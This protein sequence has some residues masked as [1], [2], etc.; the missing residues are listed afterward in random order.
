M[1]RPFILKFSLALSL[2]GIASSI[3]NAEEPLPVLPATEPDKAVQTIQLQDGFRAELIAAEPLL[4]DPVDMVYDENGLAYVVEMRDY[5]YT[6]ANDD[7]P[8]ADQKSAP[9]GRIRILEDTDGDGKFDRSDIF[10]EN[11]SWPAGI[12][13]WKGGVYV[14]ATPDLL[15]L[16][17]TDGDRK[18]DVRRAV[19]SGFRKYNVQAIMN[20]PEWGLD[21]KLYV[22]GSSNG[23]QIVS[24]DKSTPQ[25]LGSNDFCFDPTQEQLEILS[26][27]GRFGNTVDDWGNRFLTN[28]RNPIQHVLFPSRYQKR[29]R[30]LPLTSLIHNVAPSGDAVPVYRVSPPESWRV[31]HAERAARESSPALVDTAAA[32][33]YVTSSSGVTIYRGAAYP[34]EFYGNAFVGEVAGNLV[35]RYILDPAGVTFEG[36]RPYDKKDFMASTD[37]WFRAVNFV[38][39]PDGTLH[40]LDMYRQTVEHPWSMPDDLKKRLDLTA[41]R[42]RGRIYRL[43]PPQYATGFI[44][45][46]QP[47]LGSAT[48]PELVAELENPNGWWRDTAHR[49]LYERQDVAAVPLLKDLLRQSPSTLARLHALWSLEGLNALAADDVAQ[50]LKDTEPRLQAHAVRLSERFLKNAPALLSA[51]QSLADS[52]SMPLRFQVALS[53]GEAPKDEVR[54]ALV[55]ILLR[56][57]ADPWMCSAVLSSLGKEELGL[58]VDL[59]RNGDFISTPAGQAIAVQ[60]APTVGASFPASSMEEVLTVLSQ[61]PRSQRPFQRKLLV[62][63]GKG[64]KRQRITLDSLTTMNMPTEGQILLRQVLDEAIAQ[65]METGR[66]VEERLEQMPVLEFVHLETAIAT[67]EPLIS[68]QTPAPVQ[69]QAIR[70]LGTFSDPRIPE[71]LLGRYRSLT[72]GQQLVV[73][74]LIGRSN[75]VPI[76]FTAI[77]SGMI[78]PARVP[79]VRQEIYMLSPDSVIS[80]RATKIF[81][82]QQQQDLVELLKRYQETMPAT[83]D[84]TRGLEVYQKNCSNCHKLGNHGYEVGPHLA[85]VK[86]RSRDELLVSILDPNKEIAPNFFAYLVMTRDGLLRTGVISVETNTTITLRGADRNE[87]TI[88][89]EDIDEFQNSGKSLMPVGLNKNLTPQQMADLIALLKSQ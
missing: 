17:D 66:P 67:L 60:I 14:A 69:Q 74:Q 50:G 23:G 33:G 87:S 36:R 58:L 55:K 43:I 89:R 27:S 62:N 76:L 1:N 77:E 25:P 15:Y 31:I 30:N 71:I 35:I 73:D 5:P 32:T 84:V 47:R 75:W 57:G 49:L 80:S 13:C 46:P 54:P 56:D 68:P 41:G 22:A 20:N 8:W 85:T 72:T 16:K 24:E 2:T 82:K 39:A 9:I 6:N 79:T 42:D 4:N 19:F 59:L 88:F 3:L 83:G 38:N 18:A 65:T 44:P 86:N 11:L 78:E 29:N 61:L 53:L 37:N 21:H 48:T 10:A 51:V 26:G 70:L 34:K 64:L 45:P 12:A 40:V 52:D 63:L 81:K 7:R 28:I